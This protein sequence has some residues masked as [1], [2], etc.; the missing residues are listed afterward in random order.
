MINICLYTLLLNNPIDYGC[1]MIK[2]YTNLVS[3]S[4]NYVLIND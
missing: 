4:P 1:G 2:F 3:S